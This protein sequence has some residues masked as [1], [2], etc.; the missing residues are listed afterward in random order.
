MFAVIILLFVS[1]GKYAFENI[2]LLA[3]IDGENAVETV[4]FPE[5][6]ESFG[7]IGEENEYMGED[8]V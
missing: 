7:V 2:V 4:A 6:I 8:V 3:I 5:S 1:I